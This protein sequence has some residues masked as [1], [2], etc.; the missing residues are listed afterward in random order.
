MPLD[1]FTNYAGLSTATHSPAIPMT[2]VIDG[3]GGYLFYKSIVTSISIENQSNVNFVNSLNDLAYFFNFGEKMGEI[4]VSG[5]TLIQSCLLPSGSHGADFV[6]F[7]FVINR[8]STRNFPVILA[9]GSTLV[10]IAFLTRASIKF[11]DPQKTTAEFT[12]TFKTVPQRTI[13]DFFF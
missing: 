11:S 9:F 4:T 2:F 10:F 7:Y 12:L 3:W 6:N 13:L 8:A 1:V 5:T